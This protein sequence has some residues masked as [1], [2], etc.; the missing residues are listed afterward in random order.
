M[1][2]KSLVPV[3]PHRP[4]VSSITNRPSNGPI[5]LHCRSGPHFATRTWFPETQKMASCLKRRPRSQ[6]ASKPISI[7][8]PGS[9]WP[10]PGSYPV[11]RRIQEPVVAEAF[12]WLDPPSGDGSPRRWRIVV[13]MEIF[14]KYR[15]TPRSASR[16]SFCPTNRTVSCENDMRSSANVPLT[17]AA[18]T[19]GFAS[20]KARLG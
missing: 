5:S 6:A 13:P 18:S 7:A 20:K 17:R 10:V 4:G 15:P 19:K 16:H 2:R 8:H 14:Q 9:A 12:E 3:S 11:M 1:N